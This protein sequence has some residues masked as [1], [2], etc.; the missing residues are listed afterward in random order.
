MVLR[1]RRVVRLSALLAGV[2]VAGSG[3]TGCGASPD[4]AAPEDRTFTVPGKHLTVDSDNSELEIVAAAA[5]ERQVKVT[6]WFDGWAV[7]GSAGASW[8][9][10]GDTLTLRMHCT[11][12]TVNCAAKHRVEV[13]RGLSV[14]VKDDNGAV[15]ARGIGTDLTVSS[16]NGPVTVRDAGGALRLSTKNG[17]I[18]ARTAGSRSISATSRNG[19]ISLAAGRVPDRIEAT[20]DN[21]AVR[22]DVPRTPY[23]VDASSRHGSVDI[24]VPRDDAAART[25]TARSRNGSVEVRPHG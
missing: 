5:D 7:G 12:L 20:N 19:D 22:I 3:L 4:D 13:P 25:L 17:S 24:G 10:S 14:T 15:T 2:V 8:D 23:K 9:V 1:A 11:G 16:K 21:G 18:D 6:R